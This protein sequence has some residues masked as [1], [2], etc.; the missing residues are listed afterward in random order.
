VK[1]R[2]VGGAQRASADEDLPHTLHLSQFLLNN[3]RRH[4]YMR[5]VL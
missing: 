5:A 4:V 2:Y 3:G 1:C